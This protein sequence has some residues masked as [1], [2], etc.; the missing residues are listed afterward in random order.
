MG[1]DLFSDSLVRSYVDEDP[2]FIERHW[3]AELIRE[4]LA[5]SDC[6]FLLVTG[7]PGSGKTGL[8]AWLARG[9]RQWPRYFIRRDSQVPLNSGDARSL[10]FAIGHQLAAVHPG[11]FRP[12]K[13]ELVVRQRVGEVAAGG[14]AVAVRIGD[15]EV[16]PFYQTAR[17][18]EVEQEAG[19]VAGELAGIE[20]SRLVAEER[21]LE[22]SNLQ[23]L[24]LLDPAELLLA[25]EP[26]AQIVILVDALDELRYHRGSET[27]LDWLAACPE[28]PAN[29]RFVL[30]SRPDE[31]LLEVFRRRQAQWLRKV[32]IDADPDEVE[33]DLGRYVRGFTGEPAFARALAEQD[34][35]S[36]HFV[37]GAV[38]RA[39]GNFQYLAALFRAIEHAVSA[40]VLADQGE[41]K[42]RRQT[43]LRL[44]RLEEVP[45]GLGELYAFFLALVRDAVAGQSI[46]VP[47]AVLGESGRLPAWEGLYQRVLGV[48]AVALEPLAA[49][50]IA[51][52]G[53]IEAEERWLQEALAGLGQFLDREDER[54]RLYHASFAEYLTAAQTHKSHPDS[55]LDPAEWHRTVAA[56]ALA[57]CGNGWLACTDGYAVAHSPAHLLAAL[58]EA[59]H[60]SWQAQLEG[61]LV[62]LVTDPEFLEAKATWLARGHVPAV[63]EPPSR[64]GRLPPP[65]DLGVDSVLADLRAAAAAVPDERV[66]QTLRVVDREGSSLRR[67]RPARDPG[68]FAQQIYYRANVAGAMFLADAA[69]ERLEQNRLPYIELRWRAGM[70]SP[71]LE[72]TIDA[73]AGPVTALDLAADRE[74]AVAGFADGTLALCDLKTG[75]I[76]RFLLT[77]NVSGVSIDSGETRSVRP[78]VTAVAIT[79]DASHVVAGYNDGTVSVWDAASGEEINAKTYEASFAQYQQMGQLHFQQA[80]VRVAVTADGRYAVV[81]SK[82]SVKATEENEWGWDV[83]TWEATVGDLTV[84][85]L[86]TGEPTFT[87]PIRQGVS[88]VA[89][90]HDG[91][92]AFA[93]S[94]SG[95]L[96]IFSFDQGQSVYELHGHEGAILAVVA[97][98][99][100]SLVVSASVDGAVKAW[101]PE[102]RRAGVLAQMEAPVHAIAVTP[103]G[104]HTVIGSDDGTVFVYGTG[105]AWRLGRHGSR[106]RAVAITDDG[107]SAVSGSADGVIA[108]WDLAGDSEVLQLAGH[109]G[110][111]SAVTVAA[112]GLIAS[113]SLDGTLRI[114]DPAR[115]AR[116]ATASGHRDLVSEIAVTP[117]ARHAVTASHDGTAKVWEIESGRQL[118][119]LEADSP[120]HA[121]A[122]TPDGRF[123]VA[124]NAGGTVHVWE[125]QTGRELHVLTGHTAAVARVAVTPDGQRAIS[126]SDDY[127]VRVWDLNTGHNIHTLEDHHGH[128]RAIAV[129]P[130]G[131]RLVSGSHPVGMTGLGPSALRVWDLDSGRELHRLNRGDFVQSIVVT[132]DGRR[133]ITGAWL[134]PIRVWDLE[135]GSE[136]RQLATSGVPRTLLTTPDG[137]HVI[138]VCS[139]QDLGVW[140]I[141]TG[142]RLRTLR[143]HEAP[144][145]GLAR[146]VSGDWIISGSADRTVRWWHLTREGTTAVCLDEEVTSLAAS[147]DGTT[148]VA[149]DAAG[150]VYCLR[151]RR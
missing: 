54:Y 31:R 59:G 102:K 78:G 101:D 116:P 103:D 88:A 120:I 29:V 126:A 86:Q 11:L 93:A 114:W 71:A 99:D 49:T 84:L 3:L 143:G 124:G 18:V 25:E 81:G 30:T 134:D 53:K 52:F 98:R 109:T 40:A 146:D 14:R 110:G 23:Y 43:L 100:A 77:R 39:D 16:S 51:R 65:A 44:L 123:A 130:D 104:G 68:W 67:W 12:E 63:A 72:R 150:N 58:A 139:P 135:S 7:E 45:T 79:H 82:V 1:V 94:S 73:E 57:H 106:V 20:V 10:L 132:P 148:L 38:A 26:E 47:G 13:L 28:L 22:V 107:R 138:G 90:T 96:R 80:D 9:N 64:S 6:R 70:E 60:S 42:E 119:I 75:R 17:H 32:E 46:D 91:Q 145:G 69:R 48:L 105:G 129:T 27:A 85:D 33:A 2:R 37:G 41:K 131:R 35:P 50:Q 136:L 133:A 97:S 83:I 5:D 147:S 149:G 144:V 113:A 128:V 112:D 61:A 117:D 34:I 66:A 92:D 15:L 111:I 127:T 19:H 118:H 142:R 62:R 151:H 56:Q 74:C 36:E 140:K 87:E 89:I 24:A 137:K 122:L 4:R 125:L 121:V 141:A 95:A 108:V 115:P 55:Y 21:F 8:M 76:F